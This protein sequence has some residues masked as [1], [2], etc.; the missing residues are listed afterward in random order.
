MESSPGV[1][2]TISTAIPTADSLLTAL[3]RAPLSNIATS[4]NIGSQPD[5]RAQFAARQAE[6]TSQVPDASNEDVRSERTTTAETRSTSTEQVDETTN[7][8]RSI[9]TLDSSGNPTTETANSSTNDQT[10]TTTTEQSASTIS[11]SNGTPV[12]VPTPSEPASTVDVVAPPV[13]PTPSE[14]A[15]T[16]T[17]IAAP[18][19]APDAT[20]AAI[21]SATTG[22][23]V[24]VNAS[25]SD[26]TPNAN[27]SSESTSTAT[28]GPGG[29]ASV[30]VG[31]SATATTSTAGGPATTIVAQTE[32]SVEST[33]N[34]T[35]TSSANTP[36][37]A[38]ASPVLNPWSASITDAEIQQIFDS[39]TQ[40]KEDANAN[41]FVFSPAADDGA[42][43]PAF[44]FAGGP[45]P[46]I[47][48]PSAFGS[49]FSGLSGS[50]SFCFGIGNHSADASLYQPAY[51]DVPFYIDFI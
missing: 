41:P 29:S 31:G 15:P 11:T 39:V 42:A 38:D 23:P 26:S 25:A 28:A 43:I 48:L 14:P 12:T 46:Q 49:V 45:M 50:D 19:A 13:V 18:A 4:L 10:E 51:V 36:A 30:S 27:V 7:T 44:G 35:P 34:G 1:A 21:D 40:V 47:T 33:P 9:T 32:T 17:V 3:D 37:A 24:T 20:P 16:A 8:Q 22:T 2:P 5:L 6:L